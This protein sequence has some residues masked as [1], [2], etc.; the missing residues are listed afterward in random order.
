MEKSKPTKPIAAYYESVMPR[1]QLPMFPN[2]NAH[3]NA[4]D[5]I[6]AVYETINR[7]ESHYDH[8][9]NYD[10]KPKDED[11]EDCKLYETIKIKPNNYLDM[12]SFLRGKKKSLK[13]GNSAV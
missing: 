8:Y 6:K 1:I 12:K 4:V 11:S 10:Q 3:T 9:I 7:Q 5:P 13:R 2:E